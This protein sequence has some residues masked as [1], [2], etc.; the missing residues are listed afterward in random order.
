[1]K[2]YKVNWFKQ[3]YYGTLPCLYYRLFRLQ[4]PKVECFQFIRRHSYT[5][6]FPYEFILEYNNFKVDIY[7]NVEKGLKYVLHKG[8]K[9]LYFPKHYTDDKIQKLYRSLVI[10][11]DARSPHHYVDSIEEFRDKTL[12][13]IGSA[14]GLIALE[15]IEIVDFVYLFEC[16]LEW[17]EALNATF[18]PWKNKVEIIRKYISD[19]NNETCQT[20]DDFLK[21]KPHNRLFLKMDIEG[22][23]RK[24]LAGASNLFSETNDLQFAICV[25]HKKD[26]VKVISSFLYH[27]HCTYFLRE[28][29]WH[30]HHIMRPCLICG[31]KSNF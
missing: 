1:M 26:D 14:E 15:A 23:E 31:S 17:I 4:S 10:E 20:L 5:Y 18:E 11:Q 21:D 3:F 22:A 6:P 29:L 27:Y 13:D 25:Y 12:L 2:P 7:K 28:G 8:D 30:Y 19:Q 24:A 16:E 9:K